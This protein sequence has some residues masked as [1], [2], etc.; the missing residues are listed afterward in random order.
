MEFEVVNCC[1]QH[2]DVKNELLRHPDRFQVLPV[3]DLSQHVRNARSA[4][5]LER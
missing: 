2:F 3:A 4:G 5:L 1:K